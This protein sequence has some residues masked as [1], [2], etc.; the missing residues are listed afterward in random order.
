MDRPT[1]L[2]RLKLH[3]ESLL[4]WVYNHIAQRCAEHGSRPI[5]I[6]LPP[7]QPTAGEPE[8]RGRARELAEAAGFKIIDLT[9]IFDGEDVDSLS[10]EA[11]DRHPNALAHARIAERI[12]DAMKAQPEAFGLPPLQ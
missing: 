3:D 7:L 12:Y 11:W 4:A 10:L 2:K 6:Y 9:G 8:E 5:W 1:I